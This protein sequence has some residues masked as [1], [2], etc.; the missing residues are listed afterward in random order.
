MAGIR[1][2]RSFEARSKADR[3]FYSKL[4]D[5]RDLPPELGGT[6]RQ[7]FIAGFGR[8]PRGEDYA[9][10]KRDIGEALEVQHGRLVFR[11][12]DR[13]Y[14]SS[15]PM[16]IVTPDG[17][18]N[19]VSEGLSKRQRSLIG[20]HWALG[21]AA[22]KFSDEE[23]A[24]RLRHFEGKTFRVYDPELGRVVRVPFETDPRAFRRAMASPE[25]RAEHVISPRLG[26][27]I[28]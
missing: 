19:A 21:R 11:D 6:F 28:S 10:A 17:I 20:Q 24:R 15:D 25:A 7:R 9:R 16:P 13:L 4:I 5:A 23:L 27:T 3:R 14:R 26:A 12:N 22:R 2:R 8:A 1:S 18:E